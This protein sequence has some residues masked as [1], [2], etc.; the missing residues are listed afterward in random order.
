MG[1]N[2]NTFIQLSKFLESKRNISDSELLMKDRNRIKWIQNNARIAAN[3]D[4][5]FS[6]KEVEMANENLKLLSQGNKPIH[7]IREG[8]DAAPKTTSIKDEWQKLN[9][10]HAG[11]KVS[12]AGKKDFE[13]LRDLRSEVRAQPRQ[14]RLVAA[15]RSTE[16]KQKADI[17][18]AAKRQQKEQIDLNNQPLVRQRATA[19]KEIIRDSNPGMVKRSTVP[20]KEINA[21]KAKLQTISNPEE[22]EAF[23]KELSE[24][25]NQ[26]TPSYHPVYAKYGI[27]EKD[28]H[29][30]DHTDKLLHM[31]NHYEVAGLSSPHSATLN[32]ISPPDDFHEMLMQMHGQEIDKDVAHKAWHDMRAGDQR[33]T[34]DV[35]K[36]WRQDKAQQPASV[37][38]GPEIKSGELKQN[39][40]GQPNVTEPVKKSM[41]NLEILIYQLSKTLRSI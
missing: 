32:S 7:L 29:D 11:K 20:D 18:R 14:T 40:D 34:Y 37:S 22:A 25:Q 16:D 30:L 8:L 4:S 12:G 36:R 2:R 5:K 24:K 39:F 28:W 1:A 26:L 31:A 27:K 23:K 3:K 38:Q 6:E 33:Q 10:G 17:I 13:E 19:M 21:M 15:P 9:E 35:L 41:K